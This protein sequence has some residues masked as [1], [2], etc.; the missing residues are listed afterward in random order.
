MIRFLPSVKALDSIVNL[1]ALFDAAGLEE[2]FGSA[3]FGQMT[4]SDQQ[5]DISRWQQ[6]T[7]GTC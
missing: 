3:C 7:K 6:D 4:S 1:P 5:S 2:G